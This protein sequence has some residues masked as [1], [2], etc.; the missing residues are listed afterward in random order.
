M[1]RRKTA[2]G[3]VVLAGASDA[4]A[5][6]LRPTMAGVGPLLNGIMAA[7]ELDHAGALLLC[8]LR[9]RFSPR[10]Y[11]RFSSSHA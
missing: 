11:A 5:L 2:N 9:T 4:L 3:A 1:P 8:L 7:T 6:N 10:S